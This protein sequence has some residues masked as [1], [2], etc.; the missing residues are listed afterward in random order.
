MVKGLL[1]KMTCQKAARSIMTF[2][3]TQRGVSVALLALV[4]MRYHALLTSFNDWKCIFMST[5]K[6]LLPSCSR[7][8]FPPPKFS[9]IYRL[10]NSHRHSP[11]LPAFTGRWRGRCRTCRKR[12]AEQIR[13]QGAVDTTKHT[14]ASPALKQEVKAHPHARTHNVT[15]VCY[16]SLTACLH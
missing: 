8:F 10:I 1:P 16:P 7:D 11:P 14:P 13:F 3:G 2:D 12:G 4:H 15:T 9:E 5:S 6:C